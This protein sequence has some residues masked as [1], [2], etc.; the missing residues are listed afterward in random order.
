MAPKRIPPN[1]LQRKNIKNVSSDKGNWG[2][3]GGGGGL[4]HV[5]KCKAKTWIWDLGIDQFGFKNIIS[6]HPPCLG[7]FQEHDKR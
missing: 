6:L 3:G 5:E 1:Q 7:G 4:L 2:G